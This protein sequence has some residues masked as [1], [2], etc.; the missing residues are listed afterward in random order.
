MEML[1]D[2]YADY[3]G[4]SESITGMVPDLTYQCNQRAWRELWTRPRKDSSVT[5]PRSGLSRNTWDTAKKAYWTCE[6]LVTKHNEHV[7]PK[8]KKKWTGETLLT[9]LWKKIVW[10]VEKWHSD[11]SDSTDDVE[12]ITL[13]VNQGGEEV[14]WLKGEGEADTGCNLNI[15]AFA[16]NTC[17]YECKIKRR[18]KF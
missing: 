2:S 4:K 9:K 17:T 12:H 16:L 5:R 14:G 10:A 3:F 8:K 18:Q 7:M 1:G 13:V 6:A 11:S 15:R